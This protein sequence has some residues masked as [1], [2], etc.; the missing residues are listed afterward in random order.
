MSDKSLRNHIMENMAIVS[1]TGKDIKRAMV[2]ASRVGNPFVT[3]M[4]VAQVAELKKRMM[5]SVVCFEFCKKNGEVTRRW[6]T[7]S[8]SLVK[9]TTTGTGLSGDDRNVVC[10]FDVMK[11]AWRSFQPQ[12][13]IRIMD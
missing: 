12:S 9:A 13:L 6:G 8:N 10:F 3:G 4:L 11:G 5:T 1:M 2:I 7:T